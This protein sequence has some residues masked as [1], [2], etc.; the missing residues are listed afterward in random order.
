MVTV[1]KIKNCLGRHLAAES[2]EYW[3]DKKMQLVSGDSQA[4]RKPFNAGEV[5]EIT[6][7]SPCEAGSLH[8]TSSSSRTPTASERQ[9][10]EEVRLAARRQWSRREPLSVAARAGIRQARPVNAFT[11]QNTHATTHSTAT[12]FG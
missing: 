10:R 9:S 7:K 4:Y 6:M 1:L 5:I 12:I 3:Y 2:D 8:R 11:R